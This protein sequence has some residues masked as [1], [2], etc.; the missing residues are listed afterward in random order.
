MPGMPAFISA[1]GCERHPISSAIVVSRDIE[2]GL[3]PQLGLGRFFLGGVGPLGAPV[4][5]AGS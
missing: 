3:N 2:D 4:G 1:M 5:W